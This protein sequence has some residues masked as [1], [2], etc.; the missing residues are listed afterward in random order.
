MKLPAKTTGIDCYLQ[1]IVS[2]QTEVIAGQHSKLEMI[3]AQMAKTIT[4]DGRIFIFGTGH[5]HMMAE[6]A[7]YR[8]GGLA[9]V[10]PIFSSALMLHEKPA[11]SSHLERTAGLADVLLDSY[12]AQGNELIFIFT[13]SGVNRLPVEMA[14]QAKQRRL[15]VVAI[16]SLEYARKAPLS[17]LG[18]RI[19]QVAD[20]TIDNGGH[21]GD[22]LLPIEGTPWRVGPSS[23][24]I[25]ALIWNCLLSECV[26]L[27]NASG[28][29]LPIFASLNMPGAQKH[30]QVLLNK[31]RKV[32]P[33]L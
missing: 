4:Q 28:A 27:L 18:K 25:G 26:E 2:L 14:I 31:W 11:L 33:H 23:T 17:T 9:S 3:A 12:Q 13:N 19:D 22:A 8:A 5:S 6:E 32:N 10:V 20:I 29:P 30:N 7:F 1:E 24:I 21:P 15:F 16:C